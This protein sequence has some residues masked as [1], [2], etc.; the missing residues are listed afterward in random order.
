MIYN[1]VQYPHWTYPI[2]TIFKQ[3]TFC[4]VSFTEMEMNE[5]TKGTMFS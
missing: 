2:D 3:T 4:V 1:L 5:G